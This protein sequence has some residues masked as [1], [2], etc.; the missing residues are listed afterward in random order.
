MEVKVLKDESNDV[1]L[2]VSNTTVAEVLRIYLNENG[3]DFAVWKKEHPSKPAV[4]TIQASNVKKV[5][6]E[7]VEAI[8]K[9]CDALVSEL[10]K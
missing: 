3:A 7:S 2:E 4:L 1:E 10:K 9:D 8:K 5:L 6:K